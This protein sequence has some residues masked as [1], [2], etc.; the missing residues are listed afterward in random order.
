[1]P[2]QTEFPIVFEKLKSILSPYAKKI[3]RYS[4]QV[5]YLFS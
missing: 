1:M 4:R 5:R 3:Y 2:T